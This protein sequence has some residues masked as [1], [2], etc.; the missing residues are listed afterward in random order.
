MSPAHTK[1]SCS[2]L[3]DR[4]VFQITLHA[5]AERC[6]EKE[7]KELRDLQRRTRKRAPTPFTRQTYRCGLPR[8]DHSE[9]ARPT[10]ARLKRPWRADL[11]RCAEQLLQLTSVSGAAEFSNT[12]W[13]ENHPLRYN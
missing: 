9:V 5:H 10:N 4:Q 6:E 8:R 2:L 1:M 13:S 11:G 12:Q 7:R 3:L